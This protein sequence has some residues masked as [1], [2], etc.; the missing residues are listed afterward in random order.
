MLTAEATG[1]QLATPINPVSLSRFTHSIQGSLDARIDYVMPAGVLGANIFAS[2]VFRSDLLAEPPSPLQTNDS[3]I[4]SDHLPVQMIFN[5]PAP[6][7][8]VTSVLSNQ[9]FSLTWSALIGRKFNVEA[10]LDLAAWSIVASNIVTTTGAPTWN[11]SA[12]NASRF[13]RVVRML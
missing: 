8:R 13:F 12:T 1:L 4:A 5:Y 9:S 10:S 11:T 7:L 2:Q 3:V 6:P